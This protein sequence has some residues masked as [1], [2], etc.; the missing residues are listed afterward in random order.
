MV[1][2]HKHHVP[3]DWNKE[4]KNNNNPTTPAPHPPKKTSEK[5]DL[6]KL[7]QDLKTIQKAQKC[8]AGISMTVLSWV[9]KIKRSQ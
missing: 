7:V 3:S 8:K 6:R 4:K 2:V 1:K 5:E 9:C